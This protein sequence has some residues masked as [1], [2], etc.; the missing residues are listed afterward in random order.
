MTVREMFLSANLRRAR[1][2]HRRLILLAGIV[3]AALALGHVR[4]A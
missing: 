2:N 1:R 4:R 3:I